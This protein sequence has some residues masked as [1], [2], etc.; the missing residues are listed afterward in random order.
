[1]PVLPHWVNTRSP[2]L[3][4]RTVRQYSHGITL[5]QQRLPER[6]RLSYDD[7]FPGDILLFVPKPGILGYAIQ[8]ATRGAF[9]HV[10]IASTKQRLFE[11][12]QRGVASKPIKGCAAE[13]SYIVVLRPHCFS[14][15]NTVAKLQ[16]FLNRTKGQYNYR[17][18]LRVPFSNGLTA[19]PSFTN[20]NTAKHAAYICS[21]YVAAC[22]SHVDYLS[23]FNELQIVPSDFANEVI[24]PVVG[25]LSEVEPL[26]PTHPWD[27][28]G[29][30]MDWEPS[31][32]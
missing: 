4:N 14:D 5:G 21:G 16:R 13:Y 12:S 27:A 15:K 1:M 9:S 26:P 24:A 8:N 20:R 31:R 6:R 7:I 11:A 19:L 10:A 18:A 30:L 29:S 23:G 22:L 32:N 28:S 25:I 2:V 17:A 3:G